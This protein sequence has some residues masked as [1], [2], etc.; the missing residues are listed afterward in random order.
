MKH[1]FGNYKI[2]LISNQSKIQMISSSSL[3][4]SSAVKSPSFISFP[5]ST[6]KAFEMS[7]ISEVL[8]DF[9]LEEEDPFYDL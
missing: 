8:G 1:H 9:V 2:Y 7:S 6:S 3:L 4:K 5:K